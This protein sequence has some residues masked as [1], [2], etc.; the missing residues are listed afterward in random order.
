MYSLGRTQVLLL[1]CVL[2][3][4]NCMVGFECTEMLVD[5]LLFFQTTGMRCIK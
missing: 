3:W 5:H 2:D 4:M 1:P